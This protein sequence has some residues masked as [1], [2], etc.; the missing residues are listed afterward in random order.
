MAEVILTGLADEGPVSKRAEEQLTMCR[1]LGLS[2]Y[3]LRFID[4]G[5]GV[6]NV[7]QLTDAEVRR[8]QE[9][10]QAF[11]MRV[12]SVASPIGKVK[13][14]D[15]EDG[16]S[17]RYVPF[18]RYLREEVA[19]AI[20]L[21]QAFG[22][23][24]IRGFSFYP[25]RDDDPEKHLP[26]TVE[27]LR[28][29]AEACGR[30]K[31]FYGLEVEANLVGRTGELERALFEQVQHPNLGLVF[32]GANIVCHGYDA[33]ETFAQYE[34]MKPG[35]LWAHIKDYRIPQ[36]AP[37]QPGHVDEDALTHFCPADRGSTDHRR[38]L[39]DLKAHLPAL[40]EKLTANG[41]PGFFL[42]LEPHLKGGGQFGG[43]SGPDGFGVALRALCRVLDEVGIQYQLTEFEDLKRPQ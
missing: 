8:L 26:R 1:A 43:F 20:E 21:A 23:K 17:N 16:T 13:L 6:K 15:V 35:L 40:T 27:Q 36:G 9:L 14:L 2:Y 19:R 34:A 12:S 28:A 30:A 29:I 39:R 37:R 33:D 4:L 32:D 41:I 25:P 3:S 10:H 11:E 31:V 42:D 18:E 38:V 5:E 22:T 7:M 24:L